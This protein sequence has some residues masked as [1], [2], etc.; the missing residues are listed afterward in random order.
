MYG[1][2]CSTRKGMGMGG[3]F[4]FQHATYCHPLH[5]QL[6]SPQPPLAHPLLWPLPW[7]QPQLVGLSAWARALLMAMGTRPSQSGIFRK[8]HTWAGCVF[9]ARPSNTYGS[10]AL[11]HNS[12]EAQAMPEE[13]FDFPQYVTLRCIPL[14]DCIS[15]N[16]HYDPGLEAGDEGDDTEGGFTVDSKCLMPDQVFLEFLGSI[17]QNHGP[18]ALKV[19]LLVWIVAWNSFSNGEVGEVITDIQCLDEGVDIS[20]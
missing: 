13:G 4:Y 19:T 10:Q 6:V 11:V 5:P 8:G 18:G 12:T 15:R 1:S 2:Q 9:R 7:P 20:M 14:L 17:S 3:N 16:I